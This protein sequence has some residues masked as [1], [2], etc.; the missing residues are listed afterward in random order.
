MQCC[1]HALTSLGGLSISVNYYL[2]GVYVLG[3]VSCYTQVL[4]DVCVWNAIGLPELS[5][6]VCV[7]VC[8]RACWL[9]GG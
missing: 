7:C 1:S 2:S 4:D 5:V 3:F 8:V 9:G 6:C